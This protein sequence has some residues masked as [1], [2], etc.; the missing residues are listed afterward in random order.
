MAHFKNCL[1]VDIPRD[2]DKVLAFFVSAM[3]VL[4]VRADF[5]E[6]R[7]DDICMERG[8]AQSPEVR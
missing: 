5:L 3:Y 4:D 7:K 6:K 2:V 1:T 8:L